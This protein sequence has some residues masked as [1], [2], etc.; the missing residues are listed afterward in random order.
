MSTVL[1]DYY[2]AIFVKKYAIFCINHQMK[3]GTISCVG[4][5]KNCDASTGT[6]WH[7]PVCSLLRLLQEY[8]TLTLVSCIATL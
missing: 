1:G 2:I 3:A 8:A 6:F 4:L 5:R 7:T